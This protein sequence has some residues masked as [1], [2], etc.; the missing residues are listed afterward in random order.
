[1]QKPG[2][3]VVIPA[4]NAG[5]GLPRAVESV[6]TQT[7]SSLEVW[8]VNDG[9]SD[10]TAEIA[11][12][13]CRSDARVRVVHQPNRGAY[14]ARQRALNSIRTP[15]FGF[16]DADDWV[17]PELYGEMVDWAEQE[18]LDVVQCLQ[19]GDP[20]AD[21]S[22]E[23]LPDRETVDERML[24]PVLLRG[25][26]ASFI[27]D[28]LYRTPTNLADFV[29]APITMFDDLV[30]NLNYFR[31]VSRVGLLKEGL[32]HYQVNDGSSVRN[33][34]PKNLSDLLWTIRYREAI[35]SDYG[36]G[37]E[38]AAM[39]G[40]IA[41]NARNQLIMVASAPRLTL[42]ERL[43]CLHAIVTASEIEGSVRYLRAGVVKDRNL[44]WLTFARRAPLFFLWV[45]GFL[46][47]VQ[48]MVR[49]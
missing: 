4:Y 15:F 49:K 39:Q 7:L 27:W 45:V 17:E 25:E 29:R 9:S 13:L 38:Q 28:K 1:M 32:Y 35:A 46:K 21:G 47:R 43:T 31:G 5:R 6:L 33:Y 11:E 44:L 23:I 24:R 40:W 34:K 18:R 19:A 16:L 48:R 20:T 26:G 2:I 12:R 10:D 14:S 30:F 37:N 8:I 41:L 36:W 3:A 22:R 42:S